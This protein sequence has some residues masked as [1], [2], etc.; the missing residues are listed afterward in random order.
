MI[1][2]IYLHEY[3]RKDLVKMSKGTRFS[4]RTKESSSYEGLDIDS[5]LGSNFRYLDFKVKVKDYY[6]TI[7]LT[8]V[9]HI[10]T[11]LLDEMVPT[12]EDE[13][14]GYD[15]MDYSD[16]YLSLDAKEQRELVK[17]MVQE[18]MDSS[19]TYVNCTCP[20]FQYRYSYKATQQKYNFGFE[21]NRPPKKTNPDLK[22]SVCKHLAGVLN[23][24]SQWINKLV[25][26]IIKCIDWDPDALN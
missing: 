11:V 25:S 20:D 4:N 14:G 23:V 24:P 21:E 10:L 22:G 9:R 6:C 12:D 17:A 19:D 16:K 5:L 8:G 7:R 15:E 13:Y 26:D 1:E 2:I 3:T 18:C